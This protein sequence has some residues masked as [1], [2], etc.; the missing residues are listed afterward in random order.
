MVGSQVS[1][2]EPRDSGSAV[3]NRSRT[4]AWGTRENGAGSAD[5]GA[6]PGV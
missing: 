4:A 3:P 2:A 5:G 1:R 6:L